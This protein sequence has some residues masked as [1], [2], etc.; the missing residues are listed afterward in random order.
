MITIFLITLLLMILYTVVTS[1]SVNVLVMTESAGRFCNISSV[2]SSGSSITSSVSTGLPS[3]ITIF[4]ITLLLMILWTVV[5]SGSVNVLVMTESAGRFCNISSVTSSGSSITSSVSTGLSSM[6]TIFLITLLLMILWTVVTSGSLTVSAMTASDGRFCNISSVTSSGSSITSSVST[7]LPS[8]ITIFLITLLLMI[9][10]TVVTSG[11]VTVSVMTESA[12]SFCNISSVTSSGSSITSSVSTGLP[13]MI[14]IFLM[15][16]LLMI[17]WTVVTS[18]SVTVSVMTESAGS[19]CN[20]SSVTSSGSSIT[21]SVSTGLPS[22][23][24]IFLITLLLMIL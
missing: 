12:G 21:S 23:I 3:M 4:L 20:I 24:T 14:T 2:T 19:F 11:S 18:G 5:T 7:G 10:W 17:L 16:L 6:I 22:I 9:L 15:T 1:G 8:M 13:S